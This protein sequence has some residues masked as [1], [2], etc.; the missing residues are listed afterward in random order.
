MALQITK[1]GD[2]YLVKGPGLKAMLSEADMKELETFRGVSNKPTP[3]K[4]HSATTSV[5][6]TPKKAK[7]DA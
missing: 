7:E 5:K 3:K 6:P 2:R 4:V 1:V